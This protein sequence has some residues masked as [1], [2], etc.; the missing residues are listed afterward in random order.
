MHGV[1]TNIYLWKMLEKLIRVGLRT[2]SM[3]GLGVVFTHG[4]GIST[5]YVRHKGRQTLIQ[6][7]KS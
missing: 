7:A 4:E 2:L 1:A 6:C 3:R 5:P